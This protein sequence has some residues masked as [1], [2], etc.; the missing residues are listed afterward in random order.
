MPASDFAVAMNGEISVIT[1]SPGGGASNLMAFRVAGCSYKL[2]QSNFLNLGAGRQFDESSAYQ[3]HGL[4]LETEDHCPWTA[5]SNA[6]WIEVANKQGK[7]SGPIGFN[8]SNNTLVV[9]LC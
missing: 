1:P 4:T 3:L 9:S 7:G 2:S 8:V 6:A 5:V